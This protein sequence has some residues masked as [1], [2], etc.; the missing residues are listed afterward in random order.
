MSFSV[1]VKIS[2]YFDIYPTKNGNA[3]YFV[4]FGST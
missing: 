4:G 3:A 2:S 1:K